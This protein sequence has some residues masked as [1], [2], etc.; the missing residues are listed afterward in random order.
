MNE[1]E[2]NGQ[3]T[4]GNTTVEVKQGW[5]TRHSTLTVVAFTILCVVVIVGI[6]LYALPDDTTPDR[7]EAPFYIETNYGNYYARGYQIT[8]NGLLV[9]EKYSDKMMQ[10]VLVVVGGPFD[11]SYRLP[12]NLIPQNQPQPTP[13]VPEE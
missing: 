3:Q 10:G 11:I 9:I 5:F 8:D 7:Y 2:V 12:E 1:M 13:E 6:L 4:I